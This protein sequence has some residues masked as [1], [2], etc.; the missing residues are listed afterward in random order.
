M[1]TKYSLVKTLHTS[2]SF[3]LVGMFGTILLAAIVYGQEYSDLDAVHETIVQFNASVEENEE[4]E[5]AISFFG[6]SYFVIGKG[7]KSSTD[8]TYIW[9]P[10]G[11]FTKN[12]LLKNFAESR[13]SG[14][15][16]YTN[17]QEFL[18]S[19]IMQNLAIVITRE[20]GSFSTSQGSNSWFGRTNLWCLANIDGEWKIIGVLQDIEE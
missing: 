13:S 6:D 14:N 7:E 17:D 18:Y 2:K 5:R 4:L 20:T 3:F 19:S 11:Y 10:F 9:K 8:S 1:Q 15:A 12:Q 16:T